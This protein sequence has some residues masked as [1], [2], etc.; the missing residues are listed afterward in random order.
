MITA[1]ERE[2]GARLYG[3]DEYV[4][5]RSRERVELQSAAGRS[6]LDLSFATRALVGRLAADVID[7]P[8]FRRRSQGFDA[9]LIRL[10]VSRS[11]L[12]TLTDTAFPDAVSTMAAAGY[13]TSSLRDVAAVFEVES[14]IAAAEQLLRDLSNAAETSAAYGRGLLGDEPPEGGQPAPL[15]GAPGPGSPGSPTPPIEPP[16]QPA[17]D[18][19]SPALRRPLPVP[20]LI[21]I[22]PSGKRPRT[23]R[24]VE[25]REPPKRPA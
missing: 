2:L 15:G 18:V 25:R 6:N 9:E 23:K 8:E 11:D 19:F 3:A 5:L 22:A 21:E 10:T 1:L 24:A 13:P 12:L 4:R 7:D 16:G 17:V 14:V 20:R